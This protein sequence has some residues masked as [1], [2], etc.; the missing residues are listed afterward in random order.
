[1][2]TLYDDKVWALDI[3]QQVVGLDLYRTVVAP[4]VRITYLV[5]DR[6]QFDLRLFLGVFAHPR[7]ILNVFGE[8]LFKRS[9]H[10]QHARLAFG[11]KRRLHIALSQGLAKLAVD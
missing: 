11:R 5:P 6:V 8:R 4:N 7:E 10:L 3:A 9:D 2:T 1:M